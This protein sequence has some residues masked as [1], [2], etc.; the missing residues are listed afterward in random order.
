[1]LI[2]NEHQEI[3]ELLEGHSDLEIINIAQPHDTFYSFMSRASIMND[4][5]KHLFECNWVYY[6]YAHNKI[7]SYLGLPI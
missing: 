6:L 7:K 1:L 4:R 2:I 3:L 5:Q